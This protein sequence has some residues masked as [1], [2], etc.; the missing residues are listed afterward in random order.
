MVKFLNDNNIITSSQSGF[1]AGDSTIYQLLNIYDDLLNALDNNIPSQAIFFDISKAFDRVWHQG[2][3]HKLHAVGIRG[4]LLAWF[5]NYLTDR[6]QAVVVKGA[7]SNFL[8]VRAGVPQ[9]SILGPIL[10]LLYINDLNDGIVSTTK[11]FADDTSMYL[12]QN[13]EPTRSTML[14][15]DLEKIN[16]WAI[17]WKVNFNCQKTELL[18]ICRRNDTINNRLIFDNSLLQP[19]PFHKHLGLTL[20]GNCKW[21]SHVTN[22]VAKCQTLVACLKSYKYRFSRKSLEIM[23]KSYVLPHFD[24]ADSVWDN[25]TQAQVESLEQIQLDALRTIIGTVRGTSHDK[26]YR[27]SGFVPL[28]IRRDRHKLILF[29]KF[30]NGLLPNHISCKF[31]QL[32]VDLNPYHRR[33]P[34]ERKVPRWNTE[35]YHNSFFPTAT[36]LWNQLPDTIKKLT[37]ISAF[38][39]NLSSDDPVV[40]PYLYSGDRLPQ[41]IHCKLRLNM[42]DLRSDMFNRHIS[43]DKYCNCGFPNE[44]ADHYLLNCPLYHETR[45]NT[46]S[47]LPPIAQNCNVLL[48]GNA[49]FSLAFNEYI[50]LTVHEFIMLSGRFEN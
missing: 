31:P 14:N 21:D 32:V 50:I 3:L 28:K 4:S 23:Y 29:F 9:G 25:L 48:F 10:F 22:L 46:L 38:K 43:E 42:S 39:R 27:E 12:S 47:I 41:I 24:Y 8:T 17:K 19:R 34:L 30:V 26:I 15:L 7:K 33:R 44:T 35:L 11:L 40:P 6:T 49:G 37:S 5:K 13:D 20:Q 45:L 1:T 18:N 36:A 2:L 16:T